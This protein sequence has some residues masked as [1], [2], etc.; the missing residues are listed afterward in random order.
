MPCSPDPALDFHATCLEKPRGL[1]LC[2]ETHL[3]M[4][5]KCSRAHSP[6]S[7]RLLIA[8][9][10]LAKQV[11]AS[12]VRPFGCAHLNASIGNMR[13]RSEFDMREGEVC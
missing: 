3:S 5:W 2:T 10:D 1:Q 13:S 6:P 8:S 4:C 12:S 9:S 7:I 11:A